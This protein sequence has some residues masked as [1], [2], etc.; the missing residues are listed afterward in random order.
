MEDGGAEREEDIAGLD[1]AQS[2]KSGTE[3]EGFDDGEGVT[4]EVFPADAM[5]R[6]GARLMEGDRNIF[7][8]EMDS[9]GKSGEAPAQD[10]DRLHIFFVAEKKWVKRPA[11]CSV[12]FQSL[13]LGQRAE[14]SGGRKPAWTLTRASCWVTELQ[15]KRGRRRDP[16]APAHERRGSA[17]TKTGERREIFMK[18]AWREA[19]EK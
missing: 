1:G 2:I 15:A 8:A 17:A 5:A 4:A 16:R 14:S 11:G 19:S 6:V 18:R 9:E 10:G 7:L 13:E 12:R 3:P